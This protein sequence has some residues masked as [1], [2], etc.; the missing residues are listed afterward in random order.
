MNNLEIIEL[1]TDHK[2]NLPIEYKRITSKGGRVQPFN[3]EVGNPI[4]PARVWK[5]VI[6][7]KLIK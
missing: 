2:P 3:D 7:L 6:I 5:K 4:G 1:S